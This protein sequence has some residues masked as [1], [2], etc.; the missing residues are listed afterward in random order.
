MSVLRRFMTGCLLALGI[1]PAMADDLPQIRAAMLASGTVNWEISTIKGNAFDRKNGFELSVQDYADNGATRATEMGDWKISVSFDE[2]QFGHK[3]WTW[4]KREPPPW[5]GKPM[6][7]AVVAQLGPDQ[8]LVAGDYA[9]VTFSP[10]EGVKNGILLK[11]EEG[12]FADGKWVT[13]RVWNGDQ[14]DYG[15]NFVERPALL[16][17]TMGRYR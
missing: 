13:D 4:L 8:F 10:K 2:W 11:V 15:L 12:R 3:D 9:R 14:T 1:N 16:R 7:G 6:G 17:V 5:A